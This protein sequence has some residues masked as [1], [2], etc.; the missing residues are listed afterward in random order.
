MDRI[1]GKGSPSARRANNVIAALCSIDRDLDGARR[2]YVSARKY[3]EGL[4]SH[5][6]LT[7]D[8][9]KRKMDVRKKKNRRFET[10]T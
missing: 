8:G 1:A 6:M 3:L 10:C 4:C 7:E 5:S 2:D 9:W